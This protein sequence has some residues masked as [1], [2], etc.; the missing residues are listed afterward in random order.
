MRFYNRCRSD[1]VLKHLKN[2]DLVQYPQP[3]SR[4]V[5]PGKKVNLE[6]YT[7]GK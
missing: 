4:E 3:N 2:T 7:D 6:V 5:F 1:I